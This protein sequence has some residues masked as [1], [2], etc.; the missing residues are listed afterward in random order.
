MSD[1]ARSRLVEIVGRAASLP[2]AE[3]EAF[4]RG[5]CEGET[6]CAE[7][8][9]LLAALGRAGGFMAG[10]GA[11]LGHQASGAE[12]PGDTIGR[13]RLCEQIGEGGF[14]LVFLAE[15]DEPVRR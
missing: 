1:E 13:Y 4:V 7:A 8:L 5:A 10:S 9:S 11:T 12:G 15:Q 14:G 2:S 6:Q 3:Q